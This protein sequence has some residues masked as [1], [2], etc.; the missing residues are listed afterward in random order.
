MLYVK[1]LASPYTVNTMPEGTLKAL[2]DHGEL[3]ERPARGRRR[4]RGGAGPVREGGHRHRRPRRPAPG[5][6]GE[7]LRE[8][9]A[10]AHGGDRLQERGP[11]GRASYRERAGGR[12]R[13]HQRQDPRHREKE[14]RKFP[15]GPAPHA[16][17]D[18]GRREEAR[19]GVEVRRRL[20]GL[21]RHGDPQSPRGGAAT[22]SAGAGSGSTIA[23]RSEGP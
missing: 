19:P 6:R 11:A 13:G 5:G 20:H 2:A 4:L 12:H 1:A 17:G 21:P 8:F 7:V 14:P 15:S 16:P 22:T 10:R 9:L 18:G 23:R 3:G